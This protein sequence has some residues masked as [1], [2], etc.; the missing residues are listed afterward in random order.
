VKWASALSRDPDPQGAVDSGIE[1][2]RVDLEG[3]APDLILLFVSPQL[4]KG[5]ELIVRAVREAFPKAR[6]VGCSGGG[7][8]AAGIEAEGVPAVSLVAAHL[9]AVTLQAFH[10]RNDAVPEVGADAAALVLFADP[11]STDPAK[12]VDA[13]DEKAPRMVK[14]GGLASG[15]VAPGAHRLFLD[16]QIFSQGAVGV[17][18]AGAL[19]V[20][21]LV[22]QG[23]RLIGSP[24]FATQVDGHLLL[25]LDGKSPLE[26]VR[27][28][29]DAASPDDQKLMHRALLLGVEM[30]GEGI[31]RHAGELLMRNLVG[32]DPRRRA[33]AVGATLKQYQVVQFAVRDAQAAEQDLKKHL[34]QHRA[35]GLPPPAGALLFSC[36]GRGQYL[37]GQ[38]NHDSNL[39]L[40]AF[41]TVPM[42]GFFCNGEVG[43]VGGRTH[44]HGYT[45]AFALFRP[46]RH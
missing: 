7:V 40:D 31:E 17:A 8:I 30:R 2:L 20:E 44:L 11:F 41:G 25:E 9:P 18:L 39:F 24:M 36:T 3:A 23:C 21:T 43:P 42:G 27:E 34:A 15:G 45:S 35:S 33:L 37:Y 26:V 38:P 32:V 10:V 6:L 22:S 12:L 16:D 28:L 5:C 13:L 19:E 1:V 46:A 14:V 4:L 29:H